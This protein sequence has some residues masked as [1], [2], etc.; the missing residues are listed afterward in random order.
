MKI[1]KKLLSLFDNLKTIFSE[2]ETENESVNES[3]NENENENENEN[4][5]CYQIKQLNHGSKQ[6]IKQNH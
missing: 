3:V 2:S 5:K 6:L 1:K 4:K